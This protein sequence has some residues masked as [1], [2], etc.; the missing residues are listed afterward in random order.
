M[1]NHTFYTSRVSHCS[2]IIFCLL[3]FL[4]CTSEYIEHYDEENTPVISRDFIHIDTIGESTGSRILV[5][6]DILATRD[7][8]ERLRHAK[9]RIWIEVY[10]L[11]DHDVVKAIVDAKKS[12]VDVRIILE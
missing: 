11:T 7:F 2:I 12:G 4:G 6:P 5:F 8:L 1:T 10:T 9:K 3:C